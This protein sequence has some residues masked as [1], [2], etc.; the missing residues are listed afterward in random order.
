M[1][2]GVLRSPGVSGKAAPFTLPPNTVELPDIVFVC[3]VLKRL[4]VGCPVAV[5][6]AVV[7]TDE[8]EIVVV[9]VVLLVRGAAVVVLFVFPFG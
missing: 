3:G 8:D 2:T 5:V 4:N 6:V 9:S 7:T 1:V